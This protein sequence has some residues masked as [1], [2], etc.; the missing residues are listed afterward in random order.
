[1]SAEAT[2]VLSGGTAAPSIQRPDSA[3][4]PRQST[5][6]VIKGAILGTIVEYYDFGIYGFMA[7]LLS[8]QFFAAGDPDAALLE[9]FAAFAVAFF[10][11]IPG[12]IFFGHIGDTY[13]RRTALTWTLL[14]MAGSTLLIGLL[15]TYATLG[16]WASALLILCRCL[17]GFSAGGE[18]GGANVFVSEHAPAR[19]RGFQTSLVMTGMYLGSLLATLTALAVTSIFSAEQAAAWA[20]RI[21]FL[22]SALLGVVGFYIRNSLHDSPEFVA[23]KAQAEVSS[24]P[25][26]T[27]LRTSWRKIAHLVALYGVSSAGYYI[28][29]VY[30]ATYLQRTAGFPSSVALLSTS[31]SLLLGIATLP[32]AGYLAD[33]VGRKPVLVGS[34]AAGL[35]LVI[36]MFQLMQLGSIPLAILAQAVCFIC[37]SAFNGALF[38]TFSESLGTAVRYTG[39]ALVTNIA[40]SLL[41]GTAPMIATL[42][43]GVTA[44]PLSPSWFY[45]A[46]AAMSLVAALCLRETRGMDLG[47]EQVGGAAPPSLSKEQSI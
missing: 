31:V 16:I 25:I 27:L 45:A 15:P 1:M 40:N 21:P 19:W 36:P 44:N 18:I 37:V 7:A 32:V 2:P 3:A 35:L 43:I 47:D 28:S 10:M 29:S 4:G 22:L 39:V 24:L 23:L 33:T 41:G 9:T 8:I 12:G 13:G 17:Q 14:L 26:R 11:R 38:V 5:V 20:W 34:S 6:K 30:V 42:L 46:S